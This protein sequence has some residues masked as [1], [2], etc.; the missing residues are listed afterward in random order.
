MHN[1]M[2]EERRINNLDK[3]ISELEA[4]IDRKEKE[5]IG[6]KTLSKAYEKT[7]DFADEQ[8]MED[9]TRKLIEADS[10]LNLLKANH[11]KLLKARSEISSL[12][13]PSSPYEEFMNTRR[14]RQVCG[15]S[16]DAYL[17]YDASE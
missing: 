4:D 12:P 2:N 15:E 14:D 8:G 9:V 11:L 16:M 17:E 3:K 6:V 7:P 1:Q 5:K 13:S 10:M